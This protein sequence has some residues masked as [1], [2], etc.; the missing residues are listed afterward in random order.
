MHFSEIGLMK[1]PGYIPTWTLKR[2]GNE[3]GEEHNGVTIQLWQLLAN[4]DLLQLQIFNR[5]CANRLLDIRTSTWLR[6]LIT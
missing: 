5:K 6:C 1:V 4:E 2:S 3:V